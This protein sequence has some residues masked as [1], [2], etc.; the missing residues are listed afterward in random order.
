MEGFCRLFRGGLTMKRRVVMKMNPNLM[1]I[2]LLIFSSILVT[3]S[4]AQVNGACFG[5]GCHSDIGSYY[6]IN[7][8]RYDAN[9][10]GLLECTD[11]HIGSLDYN[12]T[13][14][15]KFLRTLNGT[16]ITEHLK[17]TQYNSS[18]YNLC[19]YCH[20]ETQL[21][22]IPAGYSN[23]LWTH[24]P[25]PGYP[26]NIN[27]AGTNFI[28][29]LF[30]GYNFGN[31]PANI[32]WDH[33]DMHGINYD[34]MWDSNRDGILDSMTGC[35]ACHDP[36]GNSS[37]IA[38]TRNDLGIEYGTDANGEYGILNKLEYLNQSGD[39][40]CYGCH[41]YDS[42]FKY[43]R[44][45]KNMMSDCI[46]CHAQKDVNTSLFGRHANINT[47]D[48]AGVV[49]NSDCLACHYRQDMNRSNVYLCESCHI[50]STGIVNIT[51][52]SL[53]K[54]DFMH[55]NTACRTCHA[56]TGTGY[57]QKGSVGPLG[58]VESIS[59]IVRG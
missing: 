31:Y 42:N 27:K 20:N 36:H 8:T 52:A 59:R 6:Y 24:R 29:E 16:N 33:L 2:L 19:Y 39:V 41:G 30:V 43:Y 23:S 35:T 25:S 12:D 1:F 40:Y 4:T 48:G 53:I 38:L 21:I 34:Q 9:S 49:S 13:D 3:E 17:F 11:C 54:S 50:N 57:H 46:S 7:N 44:P 55:G 28:N 15:G 18:N 10:H 26:L 51:N 58:T 32:H 14:H 56:P 37:G 45:L 5:S 47:T 22:G